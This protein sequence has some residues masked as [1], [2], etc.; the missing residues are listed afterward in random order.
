MGKVNKLLLASS[1]SI[2]L[3]SQLFAGS[4]ANCSTNGDGEYVVT[5]NLDT[6]DNSLRACIEVANSA[7][8]GKI[9]FNDDM[10]IDVQANLPQITKSLTIDAE[11][12]TVVITS[13]NSAPS[14][15]RQIFNF[16]GSGITGNLK[17]L[18]VSNV[19]STAGIIQISGTY[20]TLNI[21]NSKLNDNAPNDAGA[22]IYA[23]E[24]NVNII[25]SEIKNNIAR[26]DGGNYAYIINNRAINLTISNSQISN[27]SIEREDGA[28]IYTYTSSSAARNISITNSTISDN[29]NNYSGANSGGAINIVG[30][31]SGNQVRLNASK[32]T[33]SGNSAEGAGVVNITSSILSDGSSLNFTNCTISGNS[34]SSLSAVISDNTS[35]GVAINLDSSTI[36][37]NTG[38]SAGIYTANGDINLKNS[39]VSKNTPSD[40]YTGA[41]IISNG[42]NLINNVIGGTHTLSASELGMNLDAKLGLLAN[43]GGSTKT[44]ALAVGSD[45]LDIGVTN[46][47]YDQRGI[48]RDSSKKDIG[49]Y[50]FYTGVNLLDGKNFTAQ[51]DSTSSLSIT[52]FEPVALTS[53]PTPIPDGVNIL[54]ELVD[55]V[56]TST[57]GFSMDLVFNIDSASSETFTGYY[58]YGPKVL[59]GSSEWYDL[60]LKSASSDGVGYTLSNAGKTMTVTLKDGVLGDDDWA[61]NGIITDPGSPIITGSSVSTTTSKSSPISDFAKGLMVF[62]FGAIAYFGLRRKKLA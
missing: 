58:K 34:S 55:V 53:I 40:I 15:Y 38:S 47:T 35:N 51:I 16:S 23:Y 48:K 56:A 5:S 7:S 43:N 30:T 44:H 28:A 54:N 32:S 57:I 27:N 29:T 62:A 61:E 12:N 4:D 20:S 24:N 3:A 19:T 21:E 31:G 42:A 11:D 2:V 41:N 37:L 17:N 22:V 6:G 1:I 10:N 18:E 36:T 49:A 8:G 9:I 46:Q 45:A 60:G 39:I 14:E 50:E 59:G 13:T 26:T 25:D 33:F 52:K